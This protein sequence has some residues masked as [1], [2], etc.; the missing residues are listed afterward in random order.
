MPHRKF[1]DA[2]FKPCRGK[3]EP[4]STRV[5]QEICFSFFLGGDF[6][7]TSNTGGV[8]LLR[9]PHHLVWVRGE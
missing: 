3:S 1:S 6:S 9:W 5:S 2:Y 4:I 8:F 7:P